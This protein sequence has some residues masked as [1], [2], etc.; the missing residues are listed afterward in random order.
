MFK[1]HQ[2]NKGLKPRNWQALVVV[3]ISSGLRLETQPTKASNG[4]NHW[5]TPRDDT[6]LA[7]QFEIHCIGKSKQL[8]PCAIWFES[9]RWNHSNIPRHPN[10]SELT[11]LSVQLLLREGRGPAPGTYIGNMKGLDRHQEIP[12]FSHSLCLEIEEVA[13]SLQLATI[14]RCCVEG[15]KQ[16]LHVISIHFVLFHCD[17]KPLQNHSCIYVVHVSDVLS[18]CT[19]GVWWQLLEMHKQ[20]I[21]IAMWGVLSTLAPR[22]LQTRHGNSLRSALIWVAYPD[23]PLWLSS[24]AAYKHNVTSPLRS[25]PKKMASFNDTSWISIGIPLIS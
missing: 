20:A 1:S 23:G 19:Y 4:I 13:F 11:Q 9:L 7:A 16:G 6:L 10:L 17:I 22:M 8:S 5:L 14:F 2:S 25:F 12:S 3:K 15:S 18:P 21:S 24:A